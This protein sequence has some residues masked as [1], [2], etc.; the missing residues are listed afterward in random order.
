MTVTDTFYISTSDFHNKL[1]TEMGFTG[2]LAEWMCVCAIWMSLAAA[3]LS[4]FYELM[5]I[6]VVVA[7]VKFKMGTGNMTTLAP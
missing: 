3:R 6:Y 2:F 4:L 1:G 7:I 5:K